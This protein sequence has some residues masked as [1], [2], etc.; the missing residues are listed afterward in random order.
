MTP[1][2]ATVSRAGEQ[3]RDRRR[4]LRRDRRIEQP[5]GRIDV[6]VVAEIEDVRDERALDRVR[7]QAQVEI[8]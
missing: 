4:L 1:L 8:A 2:A 3:L 7:L 6:Q 5:L